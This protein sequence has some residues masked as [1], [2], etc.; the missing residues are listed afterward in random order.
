MEKCMGK[1]E[2]VGYEAVSGSEIN[3]FRNYKF[4]LGN[5]RRNL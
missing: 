5:W 2:I 4:V 3:Q 1:N